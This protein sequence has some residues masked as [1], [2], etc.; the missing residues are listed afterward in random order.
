MVR[1]H[2]LKLAVLAAAALL[3]GACATKGTETA[4][5]ME[6]EAQM[7]QVEAR[8]AA[9]ADM[10]DALQAR[11]AE[12]VRQKEQLDAQLLSARKAEADARAAQARAKEQSSPMAQV[13]G[14]SLFP[15]QADP[16]QCFA[17]VFVPATYQT[18]SERV[19][20][21]EASERVE[22]IPAQYE[23]VTEK[24]LAKEASQKLEVIPARYEW[25]EE[26]ILVKPATQ[27]LAEV[28]A[29]Y[30][31]I[32]EKV[33]IKPAQTVWKKGTGPVQRIDEATGEIMCL[34]E[35]PA[36]YRTVSKRVLKA[37]AT[38]RM[39]EEP[40]VYKTVK[41]QVLAAPATTRM[42][43]IPAEYRTVQVTKLVKAAQE[44]RIE[45]PAEYQTVTKKV[46]SGDDHLEWREILC[47]TNMT[48]T[49]ISE[50]QSALAAAGY[51]P[52]PIDGVVGSQTM[53]A[54]N[55]FQK[56]KNLVVT[57]YLTINTIKALGVNP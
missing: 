43:E 28:P 24:V 7:A 15:P 46:K 31:T 19:L 26:Q 40:A 56:A 2:L 36:E 51:N 5:M 55:D 23:T 6:A 12:L 57:N 11:E 14:E 13:G 22:I 9:I 17:R 34:V 29:Q 38:T 18:V 32:T 45:I 25:V 42:I 50:I 52:G 8:E 27:K 37:A 41:K 33:M 49:K 4:G 53:Q 44:K 30:E 35:E 3:L 1:S 47:Q 39:V 54:V 16:G 20:K 48:G 10:Q 21:R